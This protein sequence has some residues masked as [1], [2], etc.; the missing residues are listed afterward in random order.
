MQALAL[1]QLRKLVCRG[2]LVDKAHLAAALAGR[3]L[4]LDEALPCA[5]QWSNQTLRQR[6]TKGDDT[7]AMP[8]GAAAAVIPRVTMYQVLS[9]AR[10]GSSDWDIQEIMADCG[11]DGEDGGG[12]FKAFMTAWLQVIISLHAWVGTPI[13]LARLWHVDLD[14]DAA[15]S[16]L[17]ATLAFP[18]ELWSSTLSP[19]VRAVVDGSGGGC[20][21]E[22]V[23][24][25]TAGRILVVAVGIQH[26]SSSHAV[27]EVRRK[28]AAMKADAAGMVAAAAA[29]NRVLPAAVDV[30]YVLIAAHGPLAVPPGIYVPPHATDWTRDQLSDF[31]AAATARTADTPVPMS[32]ADAGAFAAALLKHEHTILVDGAQLDKVLS[33]SL[34][35]RGRFL[36]QL[37]SAQK[38]Q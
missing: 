34:A 31:M 20:D 25:T 27:E 11:L 36:L 15:D 35:S 37:S 2:W 21:I 13:S 32:A 3:A 10:G 22:V 9:Y 12:A 4:P 24:H 1:E 14:S 17:T 7:N 16:P 8:D 5:D 30:A 26:A 23:L 18:S 38:V 29:D 19:E 6:I 28:L 33:P